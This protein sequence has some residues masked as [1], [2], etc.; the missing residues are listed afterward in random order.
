M[1]IDRKPLIPQ[2]AAYFPPKGQGAATKRFL[3]L[4]CPSF[5]LLAFSSAIE[6]LRIANQLS[7]RPIYDWQTLS[8]DGCAVVSSC[9]VSVNVDGA[10]DPKMKSAVLLVCAGNAPSVAEQRPIVAIAQSHVRHGGQIGGLCTGSYALA[11]AGLLQGRRFTLHWENQPAFT[12]LY[13][14]LT[15]SEN[16]FE[17]DGPVMTC[18]GGA[19]A[20]DMMLEVITADHGE[21]FAAMVSE[22]CLRRISIGRDR[23]Q[24]S[25]ISA[26]VQS[27]NPGLAAIVELMKRH[28]EDPVPLE[29]LAH[30]V[31]YSRRQVE[32]MFRST[33]GLSPGKFYQNLRLDYARNLL[34][35]TDLSLSEVAAACG[36]GEKSYFSK[37]FSKHYGTPPSKIQCRV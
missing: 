3:F 28:R 35:S 24:R 21:A 20:T 9:G 19:A 8:H 26:V 11:R 16:K 27:R 25:P 36:F 13:P 14:D 30:R 22:M 31:G 37:C 15:P 4:L 29:D 33:L 12:E 10:Y 5:T 1:Q 34:A 17:I 23:S 2:G 32:R 6:P 18:G 7:Q